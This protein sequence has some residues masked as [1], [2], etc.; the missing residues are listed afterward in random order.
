MVGLAGRA[1][2]QL[3]TSRSSVCIVAQICVAGDARL[4]RRADG[5]ERH[6]LGQVVAPVTTATIH[7]QRSDAQYADWGLHL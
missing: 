6:A 1:P 4:R 5:H 2:A 3:R 7:Y